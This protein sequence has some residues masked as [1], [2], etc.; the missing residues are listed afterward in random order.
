ML[1]K[2]VRRVFG[3]AIK[4]WRGKSGISQ[5]ELAWRAGLHR[6]YVADIERGARN[7][8]LQTIERLAKALQVSLSA[9]FQSLGGL[10]GNGGAAKPAGEHHGLVDI[11]LV[12]DQ[13]RDIELTLAAFKSARLTNRVEI[14]RDGAEALEFVFCRGKY[15]RRKLRNR[16]RVMLLDLNLPKVGGLEVLR[17]VKADERA[18]K[19]RVVVLTISQNTKDIQAAL[20][21]GA[22][23]YIVK[24]VDFQRFSQI[25]PQL[26]CQWTLSHSPAR[27]VA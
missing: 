2:D 26:N 27:A 20:R 12:E 3:L 17:A 19:I 13:P 11:L 4:T 14:V 25:T 6:S 21:L 16:P 5:E 1:Y 9:L 15:S 24:P 7:A 22:E 18:R 8:S 23:A 10:P